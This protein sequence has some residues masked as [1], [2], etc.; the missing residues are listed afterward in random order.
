MFLTPEAILK[1]FRNLE[2]SLGAYLFFGPS[3]TLFGRYQDND[4]AF[5][6]A[7]YRF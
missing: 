4:Q 5:L 1:S 6:K 2:L 7:T 3:D